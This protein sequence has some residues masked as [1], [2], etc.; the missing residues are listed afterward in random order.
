M[1]SEARQEETGENKTMLR[2][3]QFWGLKI[4]AQEGTPSPSNLHL[5]AESLIAKTKASPQTSAA[6]MKAAKRKSCSKS[7]R[8]TY[9]H[10]T[11][12]LEIYL[13]LQGFRFV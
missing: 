3:V 8:V 1:P 5:T 6:L 12:K 10:F 4:W 11:D 2:N 13:S 7:Y 9:S